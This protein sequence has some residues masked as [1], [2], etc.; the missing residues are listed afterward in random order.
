MRF[1][2][3]LFLVSSWIQSSS[4][5][6]AMLNSQRSESEENYCSSL[7]KW[8]MHFTEHSVTFCSASLFFSNSLCKERTVFCECWLGRTSPAYTIN[9]MISFFSVTFMPSYKFNGCSERLIGFFVF[10][11]HFECNTGKLFVCAFR[12]A[13]EDGWRNILS[14]REILKLI[15]L[16]YSQ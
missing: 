11:S 10:S 15:H 14:A 1:I 12:L 2:F 16:L 13:D 6:A 8:N 3:S 4:H 5:R 7:M 9:L